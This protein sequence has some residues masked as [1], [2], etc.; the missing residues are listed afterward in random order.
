M[1]CESLLGALDAE[2]TRLCDIIFPEGETTI[3]GFD[4]E[5][6]CF[7]SD[8]NMLG[9]PALASVGVGG[10]TKVV[11]ASFRFGGVAGICVMMRFGAIERRELEDCVSS[12]V[13]ICGG[14]AWEGSSKT[15]VSR[16]LP[17]KKA[18]NPPP[19][20]LG[21]GGS[22]ST[23]VFGDVD[24]RVGAKASLSFPTGDTPRLFAAISMVL[25]CLSGTSSAEPTESAREASAEATESIVSDAIR[26][27]ESVKR[28]VCDWCG[29]MPGRLLGELTV[30]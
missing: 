16:F 22:G 29:D 14:E 18:P 30:G 15:F 28:P 27:D 21:L 6:L 8:F 2:R 9:T 17:P 7:E 25:A 26:G 5:G 1:E 11:G 24:L 3:L 12:P 19:L 4:C 10:V 13:W 23:T 20:V